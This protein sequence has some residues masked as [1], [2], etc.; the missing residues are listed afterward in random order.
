MEE[1]HNG[2][3]SSNART[4]TRRHALRAIAGA[5]LTVG[6]GGVGLVAGEGHERELE[7]TGKGSENATLDCPG[8]DG[9]WHWILSP[10][11]PTPPEPGAE[12]TVTFDDGTTM[13]DTGERRSGGQKGAVHFD[14]TKAGGGTVTAATVTFSGGSSNTILTISHSNCQPESEPTP[15]EPQYND[16]VVNHECVD[17]RGTM[18]VSNIN[19]NSTSVTATGPGGYMETKLVPAGGSAEFADLDDG[20][21]YLET[22]HNEI[23][24]DQSSVMIDCEDESEPTPEEPKY[25]DLVVTHECV[26]GRGTMTVSNDN[27]TATS[28]T[29]TGPGGYM[30]TKSVPAGG[31]VEFASLDNG[32]Y[33]VTTDHNK[34]GVDKSPVMIDY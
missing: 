29:V 2:D 19:E 20:T 14:I 18:T 16:L 12:L 22:D 4:T 1:S 6:V 13:S 33:D 3:D 27:D 21:Y 10:G 9:Y 25:D 17:G 15:E 23:G 26:H 11:G 34:I 8:T 28:V 31:F 24:V 5:G 30:Q 32:S 7:W